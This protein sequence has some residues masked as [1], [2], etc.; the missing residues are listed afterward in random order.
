[1]DDSMVKLHAEVQAL[2]GEVQEVE[3]VLTLS[4]EAYE[5]W[6]EKL[7]KKAPEA[8]A[9]IAAHLIAGA[10]TL[11]RDAGTIAELLCVEL[12]SIAATLVSKDVALELQ[13]KA[14]LDLDQR[15]KLT[16]SAETRRLQSRTA[17]A[18]RGSVPNKPWMRFDLTKR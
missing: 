10:A 12:A 8:R 7:S 16:G 3:G 4:G 15:T 2:L 1:M 14:G 18:P 6:T 11:L 5:A 17:P 9:E 13:E